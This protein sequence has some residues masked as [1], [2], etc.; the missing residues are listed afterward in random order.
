MRRRSAVLELT[1]LTVFVMAA[2][3]A[4]SSLVMLRWHRS[5]LLEE[6]RRGLLLTCDAVEASLR[7]AMMQNQR[8]EIRASIERIARRTHVRQIRLAEHRGRITLSAYPEAVGR[9]LAL[10]AP[11]CAVCHTG[12]KP[13]SRPPTS[14]Q[15]RT[16]LDSNSLRA[17]TPVMAEPGCVNPACHR[18]E[19]PSGVLGIIDISL[20]LDQFERNLAETRTWSLALSSVSVL[21]G[22]VVVWLVLARRFRCPMQDL[23][24][25]IRRV[26]AGNLTH[27]IA[28]RSNDEFGELAQSFNHMSEQLADTQQSLIQ[29]ERLISM[30]KLAAGVAHEINNPL[31][32]IVA[33][34]EALAEDAGPSDPRRKDYEVILREAL[35]CRQIIRGLLDFARQDAPALVPSH[36]KDLIEKTLQVVARQ[37][38]FRNI[39]FE[40]HI[41]PD[42]PLIDVDPL[43]IEQVLLNLFVNAQ[44]AMPAG[45]RIAVGARRA[46]GVGRVELTVQDEGTGIAPEIRSRIFEP[47]FS[48]KGGRTDGLGLAVCLGI[49]QRHRGAIEVESQ[50]GRGTLVRVTLP[51]AQSRQ[52]AEREEG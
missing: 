49:V 14:V 15:A 44:Q 4:A 20:P 33:Y 21:I 32:G 17:F 18:Q 3:P 43:Q 47:F 11:P 36:P 7:L 35:R 31:T 25:G 23:L 16:V 22:A 52:A 19:K 27:R 50:P 40:Q 46:V 26:A 10:D 13:R 30:G 9:R 48:T 8:E 28:V 38:A 5:W 45:G 39:A 2:L 37:A 41:E 42:V 29:S 1:L 6:A 24:R 51:V 34:A 12:G